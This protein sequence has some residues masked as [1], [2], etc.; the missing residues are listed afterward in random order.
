MSLKFGLDDASR[1]RFDGS[2]ETISAPFHGTIPARCDVRELSENPDETI[3]NAA[4]IWNSL[5]A[6]E[7]CSRCRKSHRL[8]VEIPGGDE[9]LQR[10]SKL[11]SLVPS[12]LRKRRNPPYFT[13]FVTCLRRRSRIAENAQKLLPAGVATPTQEQRIACSL[14]DPRCVGSHRD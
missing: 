7:W 5:R 6:E 9:S 4:K 2:L 12:R 13:G 8:M 10:L 3:R 1:S 11:I 14:H